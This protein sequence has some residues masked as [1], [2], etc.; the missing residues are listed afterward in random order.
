M[1]IFLAL[2]LAVSALV[3]AVLLTNSYRH[4]R[5]ELHAQKYNLNNMLFWAAV[6][7]TV[8]GLSYLFAF[9]HMS[10]WAKIITV[11]AALIF[12]VVLVR[13]LATSRLPFRK[14]T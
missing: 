14:P 7:Y 5:L 13:N 3:G 12:A 10:S 1:D 2:T 8:S 11:F 9:T 4:E 6:C